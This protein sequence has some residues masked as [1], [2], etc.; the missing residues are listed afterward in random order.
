MFPSAHSGIH[1]A[2]VIR[3]Y[4]YTVQMAYWHP[5]GAKNRG[6]GYID[7]LVVRNADA[8]PYNAACDAYR[9]VGLN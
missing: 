3:G 4:I 9:L 8:A 1:V 6:G 7:R 5:V 2:V